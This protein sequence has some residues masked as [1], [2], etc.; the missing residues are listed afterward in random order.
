M[1]KLIAPVLITVLVILVPLVYLG[2]FFF[3]PLPIWVRIAGGLIVLVPV[4]I[5]IYVL[6]ERIKEVRNGEEDDLSNY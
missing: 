3:M 4:G 2:L 1:K 6:I 5:A